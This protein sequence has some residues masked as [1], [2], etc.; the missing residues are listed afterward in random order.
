[1]EH[2]LHRGSLYFSIL[3]HLNTRVIIHHVQKS[4]IKREKNGYSK[5]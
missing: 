3:Y 5:T 1:M 4:E 2:I